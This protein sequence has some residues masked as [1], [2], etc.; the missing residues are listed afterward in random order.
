MTSP[1]W[2]VVATTSAAGFGVAV[3]LSFVARRLFVSKREKEARLGEQIIGS[4]GGARN[5][6]SASE[7]L[8]KRRAEW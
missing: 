1:F 6:R 3:V 2:Q 7:Q 4:L 5:A 8:E